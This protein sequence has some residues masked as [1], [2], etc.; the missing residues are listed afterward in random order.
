MDLKAV[1]QFVSPQIRDAA[2]QTADQL[3]QRGIRYAL[4]GG[5]AVAAHGYLRATVDVDFLVGDEAFDH[6]GSLVAFKPGV[7][8]EVGGV[9]IDYLSPISLGP[10]VEQVLDNPPTSDGFPIV[11]IELLIYMKLRANRRRDLVDVV[12]LLRVGVDSN[13]IR[14]Y[15]SEYAPDLTSRFDELADEALED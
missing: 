15:L 9:R 2:I 14:D 12:E 7:P 10:Q 5:L 11:P 1:F 3:S 8:I 13:R 4:A 6:R